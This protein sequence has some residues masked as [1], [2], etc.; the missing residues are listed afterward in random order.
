M[1]RIIIVSL[2]L[3]FVIGCKT[4]EYTLQIASISTD[5]TISGSFFLGSGMIGEESY[6]ITYAK[7]NNGGYRMYKF[8]TNR[9]VIYEDG[10]ENPYVTYFLRS[11]YAHSV[12][13]IAYASSAEF[14]V[15]KGTI[16]REFK[17][18]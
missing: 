13:G 15:P 9:S 6:Y 12:K 5:S 4:N 16:V 3:V 10:N 17:L 7:T 18:Q 1:K 11:D 8:K 14:H 2:F